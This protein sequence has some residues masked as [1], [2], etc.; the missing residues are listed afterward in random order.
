MPIN[1]ERSREVFEYVTLNGKDKAAEHFNITY[2]TLSRY[3][4]K[5]REFGVNITYDNK[6]PRLP[7]IL[8]FDIETAPMQAFSWTLFKPRLSHD[9]IIKDW[10]V[11]SWSAKWLFEAEIMGDV[12]TKDEALNNDDSRV[13]KSI[14]KLMDEADIIIAHNGDKFDIR[15][16]NARFLYHGMT[17]P[18]TYKTVDTLKVA[19]KMFMLNSNKLDHLSKH[20]GIGEKV[21]TG[22]F[23]L[24]LDCMNGIRTAW[25]LMKK[26]NKHDVHLL[27]KLYQRLKPW[28]R[29]HPNHNVYNETSH[30]CPVCGGRTQRRGY[31]F[32]REIKSDFQLDHE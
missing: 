18:S 1:K 30:K 4:R 2:D 28:H 11:I 7:K 22:G 20:L 3:L 9:N 15:K 23:D 27:Y 25:K 10:F 32:T 29:T 24:W 13:V 6:A 19:R 14:W 8:L 17:L 31:S 21:D 12:L 16:I 26:Y 5:A